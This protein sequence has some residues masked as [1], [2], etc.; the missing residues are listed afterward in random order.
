MLIYTCTNNFFVIFKLI[1]IFQLIYIMIDTFN[2]IILCSRVVSLL[3]NSNKDL[4]TLPI[5]LEYGL[6][7]Q[8]R[9]IL[10]SG[11]IPST[12]KCI[13]KF[14]E[15]LMTMKIVIKKIQCE[16]E[17]AVTK[18]FSIRVFCETRI[19]H[20]GQFKYFLKTIKSEYPNIKIYT[21]D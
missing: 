13:T 6:F 8:R 17:K 18:Q 11:K 2:M 1:E 10:M 4:L 7:N 19:V 15:F 14:C 9:F 21:V 12:H 5:Y 3:I 16:R 20:E